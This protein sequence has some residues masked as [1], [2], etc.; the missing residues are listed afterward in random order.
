M[1]RLLSIVLRYIAL[2]AL[3]MLISKAIQEIF[4]TLSIRMVLIIG[5]VFCALV[6]AISEYKRK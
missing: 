5:C 3:Y 4:G 1:K 6:M 2:V